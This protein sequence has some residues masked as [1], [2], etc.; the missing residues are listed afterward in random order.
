[1][2]GG[3]GEVNGASRGA[4][5]EGLG[6]GE[7]GFWAGEGG[8]GFSSSAVDEASDVVLGLLST[9]SSENIENCLIIK[10]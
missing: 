6:A 10:G 2:V 5:S 3:V 7:G 9:L 8:D 4:S 1:M